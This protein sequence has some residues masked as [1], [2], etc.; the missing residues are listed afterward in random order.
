MQLSQNSQKSSV[1][2]LQTVTTPGI[3]LWVPYRT[4]PWKIRPSRFSVVW[5]ERTRKKG[6]LTMLSPD[7]TTSHMP[8][9]ALRSAG[10]FRRPLR[11]LARKN[12]T[13][14]ER[15]WSGQKAP[16]FWVQTDDLQINATLHAPGKQPG[17]RM[18]VRYTTR[19]DGR[20][21]AVLYIRMYQVPGILLLKRRYT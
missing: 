12:R 17:R 1:G 5:A 19:K 13:K 8:C 14:C 20:E 11:S 21:R 16:W 4:Y 3:D 15:M 2:S 10:G 18:H 6:A 9:K 7:A